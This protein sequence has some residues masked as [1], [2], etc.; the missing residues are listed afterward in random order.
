MASS[1]LAISLV[2]LKM[3]QALSLPR[4]VPLCPKAS[5][6][7]VAVVF[8]QTPEHKEIGVGA[9]LGGPIDECERMHSHIDIRK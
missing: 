8:G 3:P 2:S 5:S 4:P 7:F 9:A 1:G 6:T